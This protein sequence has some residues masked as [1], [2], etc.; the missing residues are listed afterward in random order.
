MEIEQDGNEHRKAETETGTRR[1][2]KLAI[3]SGRGLAGV[4]SG[5]LVG[6]NSHLGA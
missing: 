4:A 6:G 5:G 2:L 3:G 1:G